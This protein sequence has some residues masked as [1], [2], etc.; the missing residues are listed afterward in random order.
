MSGTGK[1]LQEIYNE[2]SQRLDELGSKQKAALQEN[3]RKGVEDLGRMESTIMSKMDK[4]FSELDQEINEYLDKAIASIKHAVDSEI[5]ENK[6]FLERL[7]EA[8]RLSCQS[9]SEDIYTLR[10][11]MKNRF[12]V[13]AEHCLSLQKRHQEKSL[14]HIRMEAVRAEAHLK[15]LSRSAEAA[16]N[17]KG[18]HQ[19]M[20]LLDKNA[21]LP[22]EFFSEFSRLALSIEKRLNESVHMLTGQSKEIVAELGSNAKESQVSLDQA[23]QQL[24]QDIEQAYKKADGELRKHCEDALS[25][26]LLH[27]EE[28]AKR[29]CSELLDSQD[30]NG[31]GI[32]NRTSE[33]KDFTANL[34][35]EVKSFLEQQD[36]DIRKN[37]S[38]LAENFEKKLKE[39]LDSSRDHNKIVAD[40][41][42]Q[43]MERISA[44]LSKIESEFES[45][46]GELA[47]KCQARLSSVCTDA[48]LAIISAHDT[49]AAEFKSMNSEQ[50]NAIDEKTQELL[51]QIERVAQAALQA[52]KSAAGEGGGAKPAAA[53]SSQTSSSDTHPGAS[54]GSS[55]GSDD[56]LFSDFG[57]LKL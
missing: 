44:D 12:E 45:K 24:A 14:G 17:N 32:G 27:Q 5:E 20:I 29:L 53:S 23:V 13:N 38:E 41:R 28:C 1:T 25:F 30:A 8:L 15:S 48:E 54:A 35:S 37:G 21:K 19:L 7:Q 50:R 43:L 51:S 6:K 33:L 40:E 36:S 39:D 31:S 55:S 2:G 26:A 34:L 10:D 18:N 46:L 47:Q 49:C 42:Q 11:S 16:L 4:S 57:D 3:T 22:S 52:M 9:L 56:D